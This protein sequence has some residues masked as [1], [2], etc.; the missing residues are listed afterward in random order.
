MGMEQ[1]A[2]RAAL[3]GDW[4]EA[5]D[6]NLQII[7]ENPEDTETLGR[8]AYA[9]A[10]SGDLETA[11]KTYKKLLSIDPYH[12][13]AKKNLAKFQ[14]TKKSINRPSDNS[15][16]SPSLFLA[17]S[18]NTKIIDLINLA[19][20]NI[21]QTLS[22]GEEVFAHQRRF[23]LQIKDK[24]ENYLGTFPDDIGR[25]MINLLKKK[26]DL[27]FFLKDIQENRIT[28]FVKWDEK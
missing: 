16:V 28:I 12:A 26:L 9:Q 10:K 14:M 7:K 27:K 21:L 5:V 2:I 15:N 19:Q 24:N 13:I 1:K 11:C 6:L 8:L 4:K 17:E 23:D 3:N 18:S 20:K 22:V 25:H